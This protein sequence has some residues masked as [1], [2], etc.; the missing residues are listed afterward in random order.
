[1]RRRQF[2]AG[3]AAGLLGTMIAP[4]TGSRQMYLVEFVE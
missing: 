1:M 2:I 4:A 3:S